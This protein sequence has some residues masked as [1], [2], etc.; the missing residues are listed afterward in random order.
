MH[1]TWKLFA[2][3][4]DAAGDGEVTVEVP[5]DATV[6][7]ALERLFECHPAVAEQARAEDGTVYEH[8]RT[9]HDGQD[10]YDPLASDREV[11]EADELALLPPVSGG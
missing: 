8:V 9:I 3:I 1:V 11:A 2:T 10:V 5:G 6:A 7:D 4:G